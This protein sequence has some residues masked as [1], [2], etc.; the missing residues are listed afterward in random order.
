MPR[1]PNPLDLTP[2]ERTALQAGQRSRSAFTRRRCRVL[3]A[4]A[5]GLTAPAAAELA[6]CSGQSVRNALAAF[7][8]EGLGSLRAKRPGPCGPG[9]WPLAR[10]GDLLALLRRSPREFG[11][12]RSLWTQALVA[13]VCFEEGW[14]ARR[15]CPA[16]IDN[17][18]RRLG[19]R[20]G[21]AKRWALLPTTPVGKT[22]RPLRA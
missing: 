19:V 12:I 4:C 13:E 9:A 10:D 16:T 14:T 3:L 15:L 8:A 18:L 17:A 22:P 7:R 1:P 20:W 5:Q 21:A 2:R 11:R 6:G